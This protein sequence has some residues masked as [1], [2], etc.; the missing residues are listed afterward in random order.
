[1]STA[2]QQPAPPLSQN[3]ETA[4]LLGA[5][6]LFLS[7]FAYAAPGYPSTKQRAWILTSVGSSTMSLASLP[8]VYD[9]VKGGGVAHLVQRRWLSDSACRFFQSYLCS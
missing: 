7:V 4:I 1:M 6:I 3:V 5:F 8:F 2:R 9:V